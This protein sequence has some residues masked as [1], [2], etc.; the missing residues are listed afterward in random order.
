MSPDMEIGVYSFFA[1]PNIV[2]CIVGSS[3]SGPQN[4]VPLFSG[5]PHIDM[6]LW[7]KR[8]GHQA[9]LSGCFVGGA[10]VC[11]FGTRTLK[12]IQSYTFRL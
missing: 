11:G 7:L 5:N 8:F 6:L 12:G 1:Y 4:K 9:A 2:P 3:L 10:L